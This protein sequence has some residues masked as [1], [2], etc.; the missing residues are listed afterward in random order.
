MRADRAHQASALRVQGLLAV[1]RHVHAH[2]GATRAELSR[3]LDLRSSSAA[4]ITARLKSLRL[5][6]EGGV[7]PTR[8]RGRPSPVLVAHAEGPLVCAVE[9]SH[10]RWRVA[11]VQLGGVVV[12][13]HE[14]RHRRR[15]PDAVLGAVR[16]EVAS[17]H[18]RYGERL[19]AVSV[20][21]PATVRGEAVVQASAAPPSA[22]PWCCT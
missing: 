17:L 14:G 10:E 7:A 15:A 6:T 11:T 9:V 19:R 4:E 8:S 22:C 18:G 1:L 5:V 3:A 2:P 16:E 12:D 20:S 13:H 21:L